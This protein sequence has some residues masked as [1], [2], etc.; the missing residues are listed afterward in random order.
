MKLVASCCGDLFLKKNRRWE[1]IFKEKDLFII[2]KNKKNISK[3]VDIWDSTADII[4]SKN[5]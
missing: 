2:S 1:F 5:S 4:L 3:L